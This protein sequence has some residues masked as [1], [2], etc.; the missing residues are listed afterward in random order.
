MEESDFIKTLSAR[1]GR[2]SPHIVECGM[3]VL[4]ISAAATVM[5][6]PYR[7]DWLG[8]IDSGRLNP[9]IISVLVD[10]AAGL[11]LLAHIGH[12][13]RIATLDLRM[14]HLRPAFRG[15]AVHCRAQCY[16]LAATIAFVR[17]EVWQ[18][19]PQQPIANASLVFARGTSRKPVASV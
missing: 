6:L 18:D 17:A 4:E 15:S 11:A 9:G 14:D 16:R 3:E 19:D 7:G 10:S 13:E 2:Y 12:A 8:D 1:F 5:S